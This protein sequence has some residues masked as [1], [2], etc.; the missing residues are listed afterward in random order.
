MIPKEVADIRD[1][2]TEKYGWTS[3]EA[4]LAGWAAYNVRYAPN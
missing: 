2:L 4:T 1:L 3:E